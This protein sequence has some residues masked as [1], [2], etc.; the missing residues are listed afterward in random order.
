M[1]FPLR[2]RVWKS[3]LMAYYLSSL[4]F[5]LQLD[6]HLRVTHPRYG[7]TRLAAV[8]FSPVAR[9]GENTPRSLTTLPNRSY[10]TLPL[11]NTASVQHFSCLILRFLN[12]GLTQNCWNPTELGKSCPSLFAPITA[13]HW[14]LWI[15]RVLDTWFGLRSSRCGRMCLLSPRN[16]STLKINEQ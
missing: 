6:H 12:T 11:P 15:G 10:L 14:S 13:L 9:T 7:H 4:Q 3:L 1:Q 2:T 8:K 16:V 5:S